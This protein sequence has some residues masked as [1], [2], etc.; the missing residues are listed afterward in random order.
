MGESKRVLSAAAQAVRQR[1]YR[2]ARDR[3]ATRLIRLFPDQFRALYAEERERDERENKSWLDIS[4][5]TNGGANAP[6]RPPH[7]RGKV[8]PEQ[9]DLHNQQEG[10][11][12]GET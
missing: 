6:G 2:R 3:A 9:T 5:R 12:G 4:G 1:N 10:N 11:N 7:R 8:R